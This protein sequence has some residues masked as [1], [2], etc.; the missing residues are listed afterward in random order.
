[1]QLEFATRDLERVCTDP[2]RM[3]ARFR[4]DV[5]RALKRRLA[6]LSYVDEPADLLLGTGRWEELHGDRSGQWSARL[7]RNW[8][9]IVRPVDRAVVTVEII[10]IVDY[11]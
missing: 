6:E 4:A 8:R 5:A 2:R 9:L 10:E 11:H 1:M 3:Q 7:T